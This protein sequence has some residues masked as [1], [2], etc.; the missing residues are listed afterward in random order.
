MAQFMLSDNV[1]D[2]SSVTMHGADT[3]DKGPEGRK[4]LHLVGI[5]E[6]DKP[7]LKIDSTDEHIV[8]GTTPR[9]FNGSAGIWSLDLIATQTGH[10]QIQATVKGAAVARVDVTVISQLEL[11]PQDTDA[12]L[13]VRLFLAE[14]A[15]PETKQRATWTLENARKSMQWMRLVLRNR[16]DNNPQQ[17]MA[18]GAAT[19]KDIV[20][21]KDAGIVQYE[22]FSRYPAI[23][24]RIA[25]RIA[26][27]FSIANDDS[28]TRQQN[29]AAFV[30]A[31]LDV[32]AAKGEIQ[33]PCGVESF[34]SGWMTVGS[35]P[36]DDSQAFQAIM[37]NQFFMMKRKK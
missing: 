6:K 19:I 14:T 1:T 4:R 31:A 34:L 17:F 13:L 20:T 33:D 7:S 15:S 21:A 32:A 22:G 18:K 35:S 27:A 5:A 37:D 24:A 10:A 30:Q 12:G 28:D 25:A 23:N 26:E 16:L 11:P 9:L 3:K 29:Y 36:G 2:A 8:K